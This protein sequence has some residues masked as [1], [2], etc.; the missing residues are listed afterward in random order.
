MCVNLSLSTYIYTSSSLY[1]HVT[2]SRIHTYIETRRGTCKQ[3]MTSHTVTVPAY[4]ADISASCSTFALRFT[5]KNNT[6]H[7]TQHK[8]SLAATV[9]VVVLELAGT[10]LS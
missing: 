8:L 4:F 10:S 2:V 7:N 9:V 1:T 5:F 6:K 3:T